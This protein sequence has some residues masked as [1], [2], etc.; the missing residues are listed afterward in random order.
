MISTINW[1]IF[2][3]HF[4]GELHRHQQRP[5]MRADWPSK[6]T[7]ADYARSWLDTAATVTP[8]PKPAERYRQLIER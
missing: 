1:G 8:S 4:W 7:I 3:R 2:K 5:T 6:T